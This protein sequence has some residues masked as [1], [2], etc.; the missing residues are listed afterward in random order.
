[1]TEKNKLKK[2]VYQNLKKNKSIQKKRRKKKTENIL[3]DI[4]LKSPKNYL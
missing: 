1:M 3:Q 2:Y 4:N